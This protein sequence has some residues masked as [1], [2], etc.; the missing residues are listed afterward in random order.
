MKRAVKHVLGH[1][2]EPLLPVA[3]RVTRSP[4][5]LV[6]MYHRVLPPD[7]PDVGSEQPGMYVSPETL[8]LHLRT[9]REVGFNLVFLDE[10]LRA[11]SVCAADMPGLSCAITFDDGWRDNYDWAFP[12]LQRHEVPATIFLVTDLVGSS[13]SFW[14]NQL[15]KFLVS[16]AGS[17]RLPGWLRGMLRE[18]GL[19]VGE[20]LTPARVDEIIVACKASRNDA[21]MRELVGAISTDGPADRDLMNWE[22][23]ARMR[24]SGLIRFG[25]HTRTHLRLS[26]DID[27]AVLEDEILGSRQVLEERLGQAPRLFCYPNGDM[28][29]TATDVVRRGYAAAVSTREGWHWP[30]NDSYA[31]RRIGVHED[32]SN[33]R[34]SFLLRLTGLI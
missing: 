16:G 34:A 20:I 12:V 10:W 24:D 25:S 28:S 4:R 11:S 3:W 1:V 8:E 2:L 6:L 5:L 21:E 9:L 17:D 29:A 22:E 31:I 19:P 26:G 23:V 33:T 30:G 18:R 15:A 7:H 27:A 14:P 32:I 13:Y